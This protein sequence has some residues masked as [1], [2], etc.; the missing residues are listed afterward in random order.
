MTSSTE[1]E[2]SVL[3]S[4]STAEEI[5]TEKA[6]GKGENKNVK[7]KTLKSTN[8]TTSSK[9]VK[10]VTTSKGGN[11]KQKKPKS[12]KKLGKSSQMNLRIK[13]QK[14]Q[15]GGD[16]SK[17]GVSTFVQQPPPVV[18]PSPSKRVE[19]VLPGNYRF[20][21]YT[22][23]QMSVL[24]Q[25]RDLPYM[26]TDSLIRIFLAWISEPTSV[27]VVGIALSVGTQLT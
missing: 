6:P 12:K 26:I 18:I 17:N 20:V 7:S 4:S 3:E 23:L 21:T 2:N 27:L 9:S 14:Q 25:L 13:Q 11:K 15:N 16:K 8:K 24:L 19:D 5:E 22:G 10:V 1:T